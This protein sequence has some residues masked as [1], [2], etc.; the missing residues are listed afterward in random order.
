[1]NFSWYVFELKNQKQWFCSVLGVGKVGVFQSS[2][3]KENNVPPF[4]FSLWDN[5]CGIG[6]IWAIDNRKWDKGRLN[7]RELLVVQENVYML[8]LK[9]SFVSTHFFKII[10]S[11]ANKKANFYISCRKFN[12]VLTSWR[13][14]SS[15]LLVKADWK[16]VKIFKKLLHSEFLMVIG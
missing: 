5:F 6:L 13:L 9:V 4:I 12:S 3:W 16:F 15:S 14:S 8:F 11:N 2:P 10:T 1:M 7:F